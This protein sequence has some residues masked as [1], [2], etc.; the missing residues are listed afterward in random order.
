MRLAHR[1][2]AGGASAKCATAAQRDGRSGR[3]GWRLSGGRRDDRR[4]SQPATAGGF[5]YLAAA[6]LIP[7]LQHDRSLRALV[8]QTTLISMGIAV[9]GLLALVA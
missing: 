3:A 9:M 5:V 2:G 7:E 4:A 6:D 1:N 8:V